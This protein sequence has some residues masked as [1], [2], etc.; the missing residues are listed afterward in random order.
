MEEVQ[1]LPELS[2]GEQSEIPSN[3]EFIQ[4]IIDK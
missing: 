2:L 1:C 3:N 4:Q